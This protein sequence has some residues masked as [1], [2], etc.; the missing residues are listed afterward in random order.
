M[1]V[2]RRSVLLGAI[3]AGTAAAC[4][5]GQPGSAAA[6]AFD[7]RD[8][9]SVRAQFELKPDVA[10]MAAFVF[11]AHPAPVR[12]AIARHRAQLDADAEGY[13][14]AQQNSAEGAVSSAAARYLDTVPE[15]VALT[16]STTMGL[17]LLYSGLRL[18]PGD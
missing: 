10:H 18:Q 15:Q 1:S 6:P 16:D 11:A 9:S 14:L 5:P 13:L 17:G 12:A 4:T 3:G 2:R 8:W 7:P